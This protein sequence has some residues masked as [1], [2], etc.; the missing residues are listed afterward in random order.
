MLG[1]QS[2]KRALVDAGLPTKRDTTVKAMFGNKMEP[3]AEY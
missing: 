1:G 3:A 2:K